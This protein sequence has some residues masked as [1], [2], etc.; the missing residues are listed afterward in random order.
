[1][2]CLSRRYSSIGKTLEEDN[3]NLVTLF[4]RLKSTGLKMQLEKCEFSRPELEYLGYLITSDGVKPSPDKIAS[5]KN[6]EL[7]Q[8]PKEV[9]SF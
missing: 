1:M 4:E 9:K 7:S 3:K 5:V 2:H 8:T 6:F